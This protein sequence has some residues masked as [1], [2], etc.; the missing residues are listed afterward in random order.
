MEPCP[1]RG[2]AFFTLLRRTGTVTNAALCYGPGSAAHQA[3]R[4][5]RCAA[6]GAR[7][8]S[9]FGRLTAAALRGIPT[10]LPTARHRQPTYAPAAQATSPPREA[11]PA[12]RTT[13]YRP[14]A[15][16]VAD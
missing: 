1:G 5:A 2:A 3:A 11:R 6:S 7:Q 16:A 13:G 8:F 4:A 15:S 12:A 9:R 10:S 14:E